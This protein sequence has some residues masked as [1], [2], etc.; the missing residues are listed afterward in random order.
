MHLQTSRKFLEFLCFKHC[1]HLISSS[2]RTR[3]RSRVLDF[4][5]VEQISVALVRASMSR[6]EVSTPNRAPSS[7]SSSNPT[8]SSAASPVRK[9]STAVDRNEDVPHDQDEELVP[10]MQQPID[11]I[12]SLL[13][14]TP[15]SPA[16]FLNLWLKFTRGS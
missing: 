7:P 13:R 10:S 11:G 1:I 3:K 4:E 16:C 14:A 12:T 2:V 15:S 8:G 9:G 6:S 5:T